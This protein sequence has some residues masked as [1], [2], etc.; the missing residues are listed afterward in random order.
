MPSSGRGAQMRLR[1][2]LAMLAC[3]LAAPLL[4][5]SPA[6]VGD[7]APVSAAAS[8]TQLVVLGGADAT[9]TQSAQPT[10]ATGKVSASASL[11]E[12]ATATIP[13]TERAATFAGEMSA[14]PGSAHME[15]RIDLEERVPGDLLYRTISAPGLG[16]WHSSAA[17]VKVFTH[18]QQVTNLSAP[19]FYRGVV[20]FR[21]LSA[22]GR[23]LKT[24]A[25]RTAVCEQPASPTEAGGE[26]TAPGT[27][28]T[29]T[30]TGTPTTGAGS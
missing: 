8:S 16:L 23:L 9:N 1:R 18:I 3:V 25:L 4:V 21:W 14:I 20:R 22:K 7:T 28:S 6:A 24:A 26:T 29:G 27:G 10:L 2:P 13:Q 19:A 30:S 5:L 12:C 15:I 11:A 17:G